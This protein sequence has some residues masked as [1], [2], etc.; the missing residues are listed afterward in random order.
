MPN[1]MSAL[2]KLDIQ[3]LIARYAQC[4]D[5][6]D[7]DGYVANFLP[8]GVIEWGNGVAQGRE[9]IR[10]WVGG[11]MAGGRIG[12]T[13]AVTRHFVNLPYITGQSERATARTYVIIFTVTG[14]GRVWVPSVGS[15]EDTVV[16]TPE[17]WLFEKRVIASDLGSFTQREP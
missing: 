12:G 13:P 6:G 10:R 11:L 7:I 2:D 4:I 14:A 15:Y 3:E 9:E 8:D 17:G 16:K 5:G 1:P